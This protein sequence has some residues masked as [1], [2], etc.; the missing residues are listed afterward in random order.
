MT[1]IVDRDVGLMFDKCL[2]TGASCGTDGIQMF[3][4]VEKILFQILGKGREFIT[5]PQRTVRH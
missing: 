3:D 1:E 5:C 2:K 4:D